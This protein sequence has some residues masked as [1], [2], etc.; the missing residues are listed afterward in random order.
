M[1]IATSWLPDLISNSNCGE[2]TAS[3]LSSAALV[4]KSDKAAHALA[5]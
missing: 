4:A 5:K 3:E 1:P 2:N